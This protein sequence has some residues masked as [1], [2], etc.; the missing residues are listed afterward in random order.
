MPQRLAFDVFH[1]DVRL[2]IVFANFVDREDV[3]M[4][5]R[6]RRARFLKETPAAILLLNV[7]RRKQL[8]RDDA[9]EFVIVSLVDRAHT[10]RADRLDDPV[11]SNGFNRQGLHLR[12]RQLYSIWRQ[13]DSLNRTGIVEL[14]YLQPTKL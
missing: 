6:R 7:F 14:S 5:Q 8:E 12:D 11:M 2:A 3:R 4:V 1:R 10:A 9:L 13:E